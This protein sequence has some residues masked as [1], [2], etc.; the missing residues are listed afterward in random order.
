MRLLKGLAY[1]FRQPKFPHTEMASLS[2]ADQTLLLDLCSKGVAQSVLSLIFHP[3]KPLIGQNLT[4][5]GSCEWH[6][7]QGDEC[8]NGRE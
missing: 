1:S 3:A 2:E 5:L 7:C 4:A 8:G 6:A